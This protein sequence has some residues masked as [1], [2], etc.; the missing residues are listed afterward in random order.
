MDNSN[1]ENKSLT[2]AV[3]SKK[4][5]VI[6]CFIVLIIVGFY[7]YNF[8]NGLSKDNGVWGTFG[9]YVGGILNPIIA[10]FAFYLI[11]KTYELQKTELEET[12][13]LLKVSTNA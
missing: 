2:S 12:R 8:H 1:K 13:K 5:V 6:I 7:F 4:I 9:D 3:D 10:A 11:A